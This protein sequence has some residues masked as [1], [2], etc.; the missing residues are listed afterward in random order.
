MSVG[1]RGARISAG[2]RGTYV[3][4]GAYGFRYSQRIDRPAPESESGRDPRAH[5]SGFR[6]EQRVEHIDASQIIDST[7]DALL[8]EIRSKRDAGGWVRFCGA[9]AILSGLIGVALVAAESFNTGAIL[10]AAA[11]LSA[12]LLPWAAWRDRVVSTVKIHYVFD[13]LGR[14]V[15]EGIERLFE[16]LSRTSAIWSVK[17]QINHGDWKRNA[18]AGIS[19]ARQ[20]V[21]VGFGAPPNVLTNAVV[22]FMELGGQTLYFF[23]DR[24]MIFGAGDVAA[25]GYESLMPTWDRVRFV[26]DQT[27]PADS[28]VVDYSWQFVNKDGGPDRRFANNRQLPV[29]LYGELG[30]DSGPG[31]SVRLQTSAHS[32]SEGSSKLLELV[33]RATKEIRSGVK[34][35]RSRPALPPPDVFPD[36]PPPLGNLGVGFVRAASFDWVAGLPDWAQP[37][38]WGLTVCVPILAILIRLV[39]GPSTMPGPLLATIIVAGLF[40]IASLVRSYRHP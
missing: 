7:A 11:I 36:E 28:T 37:M 34:A 10:I 22:G 29:A 27:V 8:A 4:L 26:E 14:N 38:V 18:G 13:P 33:G 3:H 21:R 20:S 39:K 9:V 5:R 17:T 24:L 25:I 31:F 23:P 35:G 12:L 16:A 1:V 6:D 30:L 32:V 19:V 40:F 2:P 15:Q